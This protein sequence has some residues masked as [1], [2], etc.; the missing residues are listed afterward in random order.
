[1]WIISK[2]PIPPYIKGVINY[3]T[4]NR[5]RKNSKNKKKNNYFKNESEN[6][7]N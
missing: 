3:N 6:D 4:L 7:Q 2:L 5:S 1:M